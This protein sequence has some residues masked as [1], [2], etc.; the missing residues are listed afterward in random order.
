MIIS[1]GNLIRGL[2]DRSKS[3]NRRGGVGRAGIS[4]GS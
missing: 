4:R 2:F 1:V 3:K